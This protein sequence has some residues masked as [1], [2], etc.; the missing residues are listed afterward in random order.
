[1]RK[2]LISAVALAAMATAAAL[3]AVSAGAAADEWHAVK[4]ATARYHSFHQAEKAGYSV[5]GEP[6]VASPEGAMGIHAVN[7]TLAMD[8]AVDPLHPEI[9]LYVPDKHGKLRLVGVEYWM[10]ALA[11]TETGPQP[12]FGPDPPPLGFFTP[13]PSVLGQPFDGPMEGHNPSMPWH[14]DVHVWLWADNPS[15]FFAPF[16]PTLSC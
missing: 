3:V 5:E 7:G 11:N 9:I 4:A 14:Y 15:G 13:Q 12:W 2:I 16:N 8:Q 10:V 1:M 6:C